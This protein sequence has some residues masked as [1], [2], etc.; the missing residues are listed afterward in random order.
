MKKRAT[1]ILFLI[2]VGVTLYSNRPKQKKRVKANKPHH[3][4]YGYTKIEYGKAVNH[5]GD[6]IKIKE[7]H[8]WN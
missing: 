1:F 8:Q 4:A 6:T 5:R 2:L 7:I 3:Y